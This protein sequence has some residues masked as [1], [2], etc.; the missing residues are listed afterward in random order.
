MTFLDCWFGYAEG[1]VAATE[2]YSGPPCWWGLPAV[3]GEVRIHELMVG[4]RGFVVPWAM[5]VD[6]DWRFWL[7]GN[8]TV[9]VEPGGKVCME[10]AHAEGGYF[11]GVAGC[12]ERTW[13]PDGGYSDPF[14]PIAV[15]NLRVRLDD[16]SPAC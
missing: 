8:Y 4:R 1:G 9:H 10:V 11:V 12:P 7:N 14:A 5:F 15:V 2:W 16:P 6:E 13:S 3:T